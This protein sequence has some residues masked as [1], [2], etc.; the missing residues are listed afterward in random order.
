MAK[1]S[2]LVEMKSINEGAQAWAC[3]IDSVR[4]S[5]FVRKDM[6]S[7]VKAADFDIVEVT[8]WLQEFYINIKR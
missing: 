7:Y 8:K 6:S 3:H 5:N 2:N 4:K 1:I